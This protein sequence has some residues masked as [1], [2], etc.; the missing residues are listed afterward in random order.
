MK[1]LLLAGEESGLIY[2]NR[3]RS[4]MS[5]DEVR[6]YEDYGFKASDLAVMG[7][8]A[9]FRRILFFMRVK[10]TMMRAIDE[11]K[12][13]VVCTIDYPG[14]NLRQEKRHSHCSRGLPASLGM[15]GRQDS[16]YRSFA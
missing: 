13:D 6:G 4:M 2:A 5:A 9:V 16:A 1:I 12:P 10:R 15:E 7:F 11:W 14:M 8:T 3:L